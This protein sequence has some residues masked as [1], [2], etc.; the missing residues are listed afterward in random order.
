M[1]DI[2]NLKIALENHILKSKRVVL[3]PHLGI[4]FDAIGATLGLSLLAKKHKKD[5]TI[6]VNDDELKMDP[7]VKTIIDAN[8]ETYKIVNYEQFIRT[9]NP[10]D[11]FILADV[12]KSN[13][14]ALKEKLEK[15]KVLIIDHHN[16]DA[17]TLMAE[18][19]Y[20][21]PR[22]SSA[23][24][25]VTKLLCMNRIKITPEMA[26]YLLAGIYL[27]TKRMTSNNASS[28]TF[29]IVSKLIEK[30]A[31][32]NYVND[33]F[34]ED[35]NSDRKVHKLVSL[36]NLVNISFALAS[37]NEDVIY[38][39]EEL[40]KVADYLLKFKIDASFAIGHID[41][42]IISVSAR[43]KGN[44]DVGNI[45]SEF[46]GGGNEYSAAA[47]VENTS[48]AEVSNKLYRILKPQ[49]YKDNVTN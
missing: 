4:D 32:T 27:D 26:N 34:M 18:Y 13:L 12:N 45:M 8:R 31:N 14:I 37:A 5:T 3:V 2:K 7:G 25:V 16:E 22:V 17:N 46:G 47:K 6:I 29:R 21:N 35:F 42:N 24:E 49:Y 44:I 28:E 43:A 39:K 10:D 9:K 23:C 20:V 48:I 40:A 41:E 1:D 15:E 33:L 30:G 36:A 19:K 38:T 11:Y